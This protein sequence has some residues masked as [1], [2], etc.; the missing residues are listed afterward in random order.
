MM[1]LLVGFLVVVWWMGVWGLIETVLADSI[2]KHPLFVYGS[3]VVFV[4]ILVWIKPQ[5]LEHFI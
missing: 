4:M 5:L 3:M 2:Q 1:I